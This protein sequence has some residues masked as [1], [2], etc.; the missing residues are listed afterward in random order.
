MSRH[1][2]RFFTSMCVLGTMALLLM[3][4]AGGPTDGAKVE[5][6]S[7][8]K[9]VYAT[10][11]AKAVIV[12]EATDDKG[13]ALTSGKLTFSATKGS[14][15]A[16]KPGILTKEVTIS[17]NTTVSW[18][19][20]KE[21]G[22]VKISAQSA[23]AKSSDLSIIIVKPKENDGGGETT[24]G[25]KPD[26]SGPDTPS[27][28]EGVV[29][30]EQSPPENAKKTEVEID[31]KPTK[32]KIS[33]DGKDTTIITI[34]PKKPIT[35]SEAAKFKMLLSS[36]LG[37]FLDK[38]GK[39]VKE[40]TAKD[41]KQRG[42]VEVPF[43]GKEWS[44]TLK[45][46]V[47]SGAAQ[48]KALVH[49]PLHTGSAVAVLDVVELGFIEFVKADPKLIGTQGSGN[50]VS[51]VEFKVLD[52]SRK[53]F[54][55][56]TPVKFTL[57]TV[58]G[59]HITASNVS[60]N[61]NGS[62]AT[63]VKSGS[64][65]G[66]VTVTATV[67]IPAV[68]QG[69]PTKCSTVTDCAGCGNKCIEG[70]CQKVLQA[71]SPSIAIVGGRPS[72]RGLT[73]VCSARNIGALY[74]R[75]GSSIAASI[76]TDCKVSLAD[77][78]TNKVGFETQVLFK[79][80]AG[81]IDATARTKSG[82]GPDVGTAT[83]SMRTQNPP[84]QDVTPFSVPNVNN[85]KTSA[86]NVPPSGGYWF[87]YNCT[88]FFPKV[89]R[90]YVEP[91]Y[92]DR[93]GRTR[94]PRDGL[95]SVLAYTNGEEEFTDKNENGQYDKGEPFVDLGEPFLDT[96]DD[97]I[98]QSSEKFV[99]IPCTKDQVAKK[100]NGCTK[101]GVGNGVRDGPNGVWDHNTIIWKSTWIIWSNKYRNYTLKDSIK[102]A[103]DLRA[104]KT[105][106]FP[107]T[108]SDLV[109]NKYDPVKFTEPFVISPKQS[110]GYRVLLTDENLNP[111]TPASTATYQTQQIKLIVNPN[112]PQTNPG[113]FN[114][115]V[116]SLKTPVGTSIHVADMIVPSTFFGLASVSHILT[117]EDEDGQQATK[118]TTVRINAVIE[119]R[120]AAGTLVKSG[121]TITGNT[122]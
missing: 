49:G 48:L 50:E 61:A 56:G 109:K 27:T 66:I 103:V 10:P 51:T 44:I 110:F 11:G 102:G 32:A 45:A 19:P 121:F 2:Y 22:E 60:T 100:K 87:A 117:I 79:I 43:E 84:P 38:S 42:F 63:Q 80:E 115:G 24:P 30:P 74:G 1:L 95:V 53:P 99:D 96:N 88:K 9:F 6:Y 34:K 40:F 17:A 92:S 94:N 67:S 52:T 57:A 119:S 5:L 25:E 29:P 4:C 78:F 75:V 23:F 14:F 39:P 114:F 18:Y 86:C 64:G 16:S 120:G 82:T 107:T 90:L 122:Y 54:P 37:S 70:K 113:G 98:W 118:A 97:G 81:T 36:S 69:C 77:R 47:R 20:G 105:I 73:F 112:S 72:Y 111:L 116:R 68:G 71:T 83:T 13:A 21:L 108:V 76:N 33:S 28:G 93:F 91:W 3:H 26:A 101:V 65:T 7:G 85:C 89:P 12:A 35:K 8:I 104:C 62:V 55:A 46:G 59:A 41:F 15:D 106:P 58:A 31:I